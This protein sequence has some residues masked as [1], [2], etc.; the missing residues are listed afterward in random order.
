VIHF[1]SGTTLVKGDPDCTGNFGWLM[2][3][4]TH[5]WQGEHTGPFY[6]AHALYSQNTE[7]YDYKGDHPDEETALE[8]ADA[9]GQGIDDINPEQQGD[10]VKD[11]YCRL[12]TGA[13]VTAWQPFV[14][15]LTA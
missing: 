15:A 6:M 5:V 1:P 4:L 14:A 9:A 11:Y 2:H 12:S 13:D 3:E 8:A 10:I 7:G